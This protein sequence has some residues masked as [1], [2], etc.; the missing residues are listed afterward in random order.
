MNEYIRKGV[1]KELKSK[2]Q[3]SL[4]IISG[5]G[6]AS[7]PFDSIKELKKVENDE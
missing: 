1:D 6:T 3:E 7:E 4:E 5:L 2:K